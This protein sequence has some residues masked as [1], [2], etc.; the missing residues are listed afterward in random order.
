MTDRD[1]LQGAQTQAVRVLLAA[2]GEAETPGM[3]E[4]FQVSWRTLSHAADVMK[5]PAPLRLVICSLAAVRK[6]FSGR[7]GSA[8]N[9]NTRAQAVALQRRLDHD[10]SG[11]FRVE[12]AYAS[13]KPSLEQ[14]LEPAADHAIQLVISMIPSDSRLS[15]GLICH[16]LE[17]KAAQQAQT[18]V[19]ARLW[20]SPELI[21]VH[22]QHVVQQ[23][24]RNVASASCLVLLLHGT[25]VR[26]QHGNK[27]GFHT[28]EQEKAAYASAL[29]DALQAL[30][31]GPWTRIELA[32]L[33]HGVGGQWSSPTLEER[34]DQLAEEGIHDVVVYAC[35]HL[36]DGGETAGLPRTLASSGVKNAR[37]LPCLNSFPPLIDYLAKRVLDAMEHQQGSCCCDRCPLMADRPDAGKSA[38]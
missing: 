30:P 5:L 22:C 34:M 23:Y 15:C 33:N 9:Q 4:N 29:R 38:V 11:R 28:G 36:V 18:S 19:L 3:A 8:H 6:R 16:A 7:P 10:A 35:E 32:Y 13:S 20:D 17:G 24:P 14:Q 37:L 26:D 21:D 31:E 27:P 1:P 12:P 25:L 2:H